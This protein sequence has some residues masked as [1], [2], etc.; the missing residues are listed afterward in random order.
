MTQNFAQSIITGTQ[1]GQ[2][3]ELNRALQPLQIQAAETGLQKQQLQT[4]ALESQANIS[5][6][7]QNLTSLEGAIDAGLSEG[8][9][10]QSLQNSRNQVLQQGGNTQDTDEALQALEQGGLPQLQQFMQQGRTAFE[11]AGLLAPLAA[12]S[13]S[14]AEEIT[15]EGDQKVRLE[16][17][18]QEADAGA[19]LAKT[20]DALRKEVSVI[21]KDSGFNKIVPAFDRITASADEPSAAGDLALIF[22]Y[23]KML[24]PGS[25]VREGEFATAANS[26]GVDQRI[27]GILNNIINGERLT[28]AQRKDFLSRA[29]KL[30]TAS[31]S[32]FEKQIKP[33]MN[34]GSNRDLTQ[35]QILGEGFF[36]SFSAA[37]IA[38]QEDDA[39][40]TTPPAVVIS[41]QVKALS[42]EDLKRLLEQ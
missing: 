6:T 28:P 42:D 7:I 37:E 5:N 27:R 33:I 18:K 1:T 17:V 38:T 41:P 24:D 29:N 11:R 21:A 12:P 32:R 36:E 23:M 16:R 39:Q 15:L 10:I 3:A 9:I 8:Q 13:L 4:A 22:N 40:P 35:D 14:R 26:A 34:I 20:A 25:T 31:K 19:D 2:K 30:F